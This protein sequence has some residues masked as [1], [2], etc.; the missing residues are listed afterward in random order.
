MRNLPACLITGRQ[1]SS[2]TGIILPVHHQR[3]S[4][5]LEHMARH[6]AEDQLAQARMRVGTHDE[7]ITGKFIGRGQKP[8]ASPFTHGLKR[9]SI[10]CEAVRGEVLLEIRREWSAPL[11]IF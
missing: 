3:D 1:D 8:G 11:I 6:A 7:Q 4:G 2:T 5:V 9:R 10:G